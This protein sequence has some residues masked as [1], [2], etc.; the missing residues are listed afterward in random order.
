MTAALDGTARRLFR[1]ALELVRSYP[2]GDPDTPPALGGWPAPAPAPP[3]HREG[4]PAGRPDDLWS[5][6]G[7]LRA[8]DTTIAEEMARSRERIIRFSGRYNAFEHVANTDA[9]VAERTAEA[10]AGRW[11]GPLHGVPFS[12][13]DVI[14]VAGMPTVASSDAYPN[15][16][17]E[18]DGLAVHRLRQAGAIVVG[19]TSTHEFAL[20]VTSPQARNPWDSTRIPG[21]SSGGSAISIV[22]GMAAASLGTDTRASIRVPAALCG[23]VGFK[24]SYG[25]VPADGLVT[26]SWS[27]DHITPM[28]RSVRDIALLMDVLTGAPDIYRAALPGSVRGKRF[29]YAPAFLDGA[30]AGVAA[31]FDEALRAASAAGA[32]IVEADAPTA[33]DLALANAAGMI[34]SRCEAASY[35]Q[36]LG[37]E[38]SRCTPETFGQL[39]EATG[40]LATDYLRAQ[41]LRTVLRARI[42]AALGEADAFIMPTSKVLAPRV[43]E[44]DQYLLVLSENCIPWSFVDLPAISVPVG[45]ACGLPVGLQIVGP[46]GGDLSTLALAHG[47]ESL[48]PPLPVWTPDDAVAG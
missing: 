42:L 34:V 36:D 23:V 15:R 16:L 38:L 11:R 7:R 44:A 25:R 4:T 6:A 14:H 27:M 40:V 29:R 2:L 35:H 45:L 22:T 10:R 9:V 33:E 8:G 19:K 43:R 48:L 12:V 46:P 41:R 31:V 3:H 37:T 32:A 26:L 20:G 1:E 47:I 21:G 18:S 30:E 28:A 13:K 24:A 5:L 17:A 39:A